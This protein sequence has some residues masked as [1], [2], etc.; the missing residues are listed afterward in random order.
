MDKNTLFQ[1]IN[2][3]DLKSIQQEVLDYLAQNPELE[4]CD[5]NLD[6][7][8][9]RFPLLPKLRSFLLSKAKIEVIPEQVVH[10]VFPYKKSKIHVDGLKKPL[11]KKMPWVTNHALIAHQYVLIIPVQHTEISLNYWYRN[12][13]VA[14]DQEFIHHHLREYYPYDLH[15]SF[16]KDG[17]DLKPIGSTS[18]DKPTFVKSNIYHQVDNSKNSEVRKVIVIRF[19]EMESY[20]HLDRVF[21]Y[22]D[23][24]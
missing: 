1:K 17:I 6:E 23:L 19:K 2:I 20:D 15:L 24:I 16:L 12:E 22:R 5:D 18:I 11:G 4:N 14:D 10:V 21:D 8:F 7:H 3:P 13:D 9:L